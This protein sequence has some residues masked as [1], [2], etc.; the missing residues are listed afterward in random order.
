MLTAAENPG[1]GDA[2]AFGQRA[3]GL[4]VRQQD[5]TQHRQRTLRS[6]PTLASEQFVDGHRVG[7]SGAAQDR[8]SRRDLSGVQPSFERGAGNSDVIGAIEGE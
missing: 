8:L 6:P 4:R 5:R 1:E 7:V 2:L 3:E